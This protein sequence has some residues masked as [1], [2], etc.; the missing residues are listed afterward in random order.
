MDSPQLDLGTTVR[1][2]V[3]STSSVWDDAR[4]ALLETVYVLITVEQSR[5]M[6]APRFA[7][8]PQ[9]HVPATLLEGTWEQMDPVNLEVTLLMRVRR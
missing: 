2:G 5:S 8:G 9:S 4:V 6:G 3:R 1:Q 7:G